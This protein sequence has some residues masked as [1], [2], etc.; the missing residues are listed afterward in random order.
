[1]EPTSQEQYSKEAAEADQKKRKEG[2]LA[3]ESN[4]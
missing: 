4:T 2:I 1:V 3:I